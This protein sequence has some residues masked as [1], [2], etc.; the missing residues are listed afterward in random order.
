MSPARRLLVFCRAPRP[1][2]V[3]TRLIPALGAAGA[4]ALYRR[5]LGRTVAAAAR[6]PGG[7]V[8]L[9][10]HPDC[11]DP[12]LRDLGA[13]HG[14][15]LYPQRGGDL[16]ARMAHA[17][18]AGG[19]GVLC[20]SDCPGLGPDRLE[21]ACRAL[22]GGAEAV[23]TPAADGGYV[24]V[25]LGAPRPE[26]FSGMPWGGPWVMAETRARLRR[27]GL[28]WREL[29][30]LRDVDRPADLAWLGRDYPALLPGAGVRPGPAGA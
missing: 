23:F 14:A 25:G 26:P 1:G 24:L 11:G 8:E 15:A 9:W 12:L 28:A 5:L 27:A 10:C 21:A 2:E 6:V 13:A 16:G 19:G 4:A 29:A 20:G 17:L 3:K 22:E 30:T 18:G 7:R